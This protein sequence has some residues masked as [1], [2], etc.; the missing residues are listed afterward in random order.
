MVIV[1]GGP[2]SKSTE[3]GM[4]VEP[5]SKLLK[6]TMLLPRTLPVLPTMQWVAVFMV[7]SRAPCTSQVPDPS[8]GIASP[9]KRDKKASARPSTNRFPVAWMVDVAPSQQLTKTTE[10]SCGGLIA[11]P[12]K[13]SPSLRVFPIDTRI[14]LWLAT[15]ESSEVINTKLAYPP[16]QNQSSFVWLPL[17]ITRPS[18]FDEAPGSMPMG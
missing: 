3:M 4:Q 15:I 9:T 11:G 18:G 10:S 5:T 6:T 16:G 8:C 12:M 13:V 1:C 14:V 17:N 7:P 2:S